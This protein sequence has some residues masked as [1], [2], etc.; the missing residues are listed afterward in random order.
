ML[1]E[2]VISYIDSLIKRLH[3]LDGEFETVGGYIPRTFQRS[4]VTRIFKNGVI[5]KNGNISNGQ[6]KQSSVF[7]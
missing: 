1:M 5:A 2:S 4:G 7:I 6:R 3:V